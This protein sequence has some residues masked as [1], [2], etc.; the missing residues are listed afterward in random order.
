MNVSFVKMAVGSKSRFIYG[1]ML[2]LN[3]TVITHRLPISTTHS[4]NHI[5]VIYR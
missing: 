1:L 4:V 2:W 5:F 3:S